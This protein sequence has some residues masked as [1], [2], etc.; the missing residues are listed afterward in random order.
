MTKDTMTTA[1]LFGANMPITPPTTATTAPQ[2][3]ALPLLPRMFASGS[4]MTMP[5]AVGTAPMIASVP[6]S[7]PP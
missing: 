5:M 3:M 1:K 4:A 7:W 2:R 6:W